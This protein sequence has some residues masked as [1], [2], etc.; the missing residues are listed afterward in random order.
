MKI[1]N[2]TKT[3]IDNYRK[4][5]LPTEQERDFRSIRMAVFQAVLTAGMVLL[6]FGSI[7]SL[8]FL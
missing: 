1:D 7:L 4:T 3:A 5:N 2:A 8:L 6:I